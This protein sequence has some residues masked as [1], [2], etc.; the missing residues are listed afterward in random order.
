MRSTVHPLARFL[1]V[2]TSSAICYFLIM[3][4]LQKAFALAP[5]AASGGAYSLTFGVTYLL[6]RGWTFGSSAAHNRALPR[7]AAVQLSLLVLTTLAV[8][9]VSF[10]FPG[11]SPLPISLLAT[12][13]A[14]GMSFIISS[15]WVFGNVSKDTK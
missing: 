1:L 12:I 9:G 14:A 15:K 10:E 2:G 4:L 11:V 3:L 8:R 7:Y 5:W 13:F 6:Q